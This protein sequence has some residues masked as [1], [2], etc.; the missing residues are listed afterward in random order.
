MARYALVVTLKGR[1]IDIDLHTEIDSKVK[2]EIPIG[3]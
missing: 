2:V 1:R 3:G